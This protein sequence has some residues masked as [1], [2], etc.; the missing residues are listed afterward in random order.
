MVRDFDAF[1]LAFFGLFFH[2]NAQNAIRVL[3]THRV[4]VCTPRQPNGAFRLAHTPLLNVEI[5]CLFTVFLTPLSLH[6]K[7]VIIHRDVY[8]FLLVPRKV[9]LDAKLAV[10]LAGR[11]QGERNARVRKLLCMK[12]ITMMKLQWAYARRTHSCVIT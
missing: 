9:H 2:T 3:G 6:G 4:C 1:A 5:L 7:D 12:T 11:N 10:G 8:V